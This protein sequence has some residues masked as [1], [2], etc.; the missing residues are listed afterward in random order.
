MSTTRIAAALFALSL[1][2]PALAAAQGRPRPKP[3][4]GPPPG[5]AV[6]GYG[7]F[8]STVL[9]ATETFRAVADRASA[10]T[11]GAGAQVTGLWRGLFADV[12]VSQLVRDGERVFVD[13]A[14]AIFELGIP[15]EVTM[16]PVD[17]A[18]GW[19][20]AFGRVSPYAGAGLTLLSYEE[21][22]G[23]AE[24]SDDVTRSGTG[25]LVL[26]GVDVQVWRWIHAGAE[27]RYRRVS[28][29]LGEGGVSGHFG[30]ENAGGF[31]SAVRLSF[32]R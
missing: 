23:F 21:A 15:L 8:G 13:D 6:R 12:A 14:G 19:R 24:P 16:R 3:A 9:A 26:A 28:G 2:V 7:T 5:V 32:G 30:E 27:L 25:P 29:I 18:A 11:F 4:P 22:S 31:S 10:S 1:A 17:L 20:F